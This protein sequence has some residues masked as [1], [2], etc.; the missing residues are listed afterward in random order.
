[1]TTG[2]GP[3]ASPTSPPPGGTGN[4]SAHGADSA[5]QRHSKAFV[6]KPDQVGEARRFLAGILN[7][8]PAAADAIL[9][10]SELASNCVVHS[11]SAERSGTFTVIAEIQDGEYVRIEARDDG[12]PWIPHEDTD[13][14]P[15]GLD[16][17]A[18]L[19]PKSGVSGD[20]LTGWTS[21][22]VIAWNPAPS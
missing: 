9:V 13:D 7:G 3:T 11:T 21:W 16:I 8:C 12:G 22:A 17:V 4:T 18:A 20:P 14:R 5:P 15:H 19:A 6:A 1:M 10:V 2:N